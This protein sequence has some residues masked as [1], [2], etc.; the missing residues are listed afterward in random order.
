MSYDDAMRASR[1]FYAVTTMETTPPCAPHT[2]PSHL[3]LLRK[4]SFAFLVSA[5]RS[6]Y[7]ASGTRTVAEDIGDLAKSDG[8]RPDRSVRTLPPSW[9][10][11]HTCRLSARRAQP[12]RVDDRSRCRGSRC[13]GWRAPRRGGGAGGR[14]SAASAAGRDGRVRVRVVAVRRARG[15]TL[16]GTATGASATCGAAPVLFL[17]TWQPQRPGW[18]LPPRCGDA[19]PSR[20][21]SGASAAATWRRV[22]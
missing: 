12:P 4:N 22:A 1:P 8:A 10:V 9:C 19:S 11:R 21:A 3:R 7:P 20:P 15:S 17:S 18:L 6:S 2:L 16:D 5:C 14:S 13:W